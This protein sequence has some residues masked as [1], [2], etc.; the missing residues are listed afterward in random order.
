MVETTSSHSEKQSAG[1]RPSDFETVLDHLS[2]TPGITARE[3]GADLR[4]SGHTHFTTKLVNQILYRLFATQFVERDGS[5]DKPRWTVSQSWESGTH[6]KSQKVLVKRPLRIESAPS[7]VFRIADTE[8]RILEDGSLSPND[9]YIQPDW[10]GTHIVVSVNTNHPF[11]LMRLTTDRDY[12]LFRLTTAVDAYV[13]WQI[14]R[15]TEP[16]D[17]TE[18]MKLRDYALRFCTLEVTEQSTNE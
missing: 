13:Q 9:S 10:V 4:K 12:A 11:W 3:L 18:V 5:N 7:V 1:I 16:P 17:A 6:S 8:V 15:L 14:A 2:R